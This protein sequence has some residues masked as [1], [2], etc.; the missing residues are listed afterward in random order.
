MNLLKAKARAED[1]MEKHGLLEKDWQFQWSANKFHGQCFHKEKLIVLSTRM[2]SVNT[3]AVVEDTIL[4]EIAH[5]FTPNHGHD[6]VWQRKAMELGATPRAI[7]RNGKV[8]KMEGNLV[9]VA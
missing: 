2:T 5:A 9:L 1:L 3:E 4:H 6:E 8:F 7:C